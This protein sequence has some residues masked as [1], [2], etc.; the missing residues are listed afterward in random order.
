MLEEALEGLGKESGDKHVEDLAR[1]VR[2][3]VTKESK[4]K[5][6]VGG[7][8]GDEEI[9]ETTIESEATGVI[10]GALSHEQEETEK[11]TQ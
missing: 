11:I 3:L 9:A 5:D 6:S 10:N 7:G 8:D 2:G 1:R 4:G